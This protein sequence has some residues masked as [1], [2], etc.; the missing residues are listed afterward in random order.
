MEKTKHGLDL[1]LLVLL[2]LMG[3]IAVA[4]TVGS[5]D[6]YLNYAVVAFQILVMLDIGTT[7]VVLKVKI[8]WSFSTNYVRDLV[9][10][11]CHTSHLSEPATA[12]Q[13]SG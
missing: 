8:S 4:L 13:C 12:D 6:K 7:A 5:N 9:C 1:M 3:T 11:A 10:H 2:A